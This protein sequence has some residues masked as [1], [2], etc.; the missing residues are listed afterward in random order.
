MKDAVTRKRKAM[1][2]ANHWHYCWALQIF[3]LLF[4]CFTWITNDLMSTIYFIICAVLMSTLKYI[5]HFKF[6]CSAS[7]ICLFIVTFGTWKLQFLVQV[8]EKSLNFVLSVC[9]EPWWLTVIV[10]VCVLDRVWW[11]CWHVWSPVCCWCQLVKGAG[12]C[13]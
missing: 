10:S 1:D 11:V 3:K 9:Y 5:F 6:W 13:V 7:M 4:I 12:Q 2:D 8:L